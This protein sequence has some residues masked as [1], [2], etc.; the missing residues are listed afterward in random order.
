MTRFIAEVSSNH[1]VDLSRCLDFIDIA[2]ALKCTAV[3]F[4]L[5]RIDRLFAPEILQASAEHNARRDWELPSEFIPKLAEHCQQVGIKFC[6][7]PFDLEAVNT[8]EPYVAFYKIASYELTWD[9]LLAACACT[10]KPV[11]LST[12]MANL[13]EVQ[14][15]VAVL[16]D[17]QCQDLTLLHCVSAY[18]ARIEECNLAAIQTLRDHFGCKVGWSDH[19]VNADVIQRARTHWQAD[20]IEFH[21]DL[22]GQGAE[23]DNGHCWLPQQIAA[24]I[25]DTHAVV[26]KRMNE[27]DESHSS[28]LADGN[29]I[30]QPVTRELT[31]RDWRADPEDGLR[32]FKSIRAEYG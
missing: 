4:Q 14:H 23:F 10:G 29:G 18:P 17:N 2:A 8:L 7:T 15:A 27:T 20:V 1:H 5:F 21:L 11:V 32:P 24:L 3:K 31:E 6:C 22:D 30:K 9:A 13:D 26:I 25:D 19:T 16:R 12:G 28:Q